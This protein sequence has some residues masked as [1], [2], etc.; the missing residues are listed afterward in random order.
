MNLGFKR[1]FVPLVR[2][3]D[4]THTI[5]GGKRWRVGMRGD[6]WENMRGPK[7]SARPQTLIF[8]AP[9]VDVEDIQI[10]LNEDE[11]EI[12]IEGNK[13]EIDE[14][15]AFARRDGFLSLLDMC[16]FWSVEHGT[17]GVVDFDGQV[18]HWDYERRSAEK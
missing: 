18:I 14:A 17:G 12:V 15:E 11:W 10:R 2:D 1:R 6:L 16:N 5:R 3:G 8:R 13:L 7:T 4:K 9:V